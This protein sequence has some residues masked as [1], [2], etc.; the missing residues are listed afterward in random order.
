MLEFV[1]IFYFPPF[2]CISPISDFVVIPSD[3]EQ[4]HWQRSGTVPET[5]P[6]R[7]HPVQNSET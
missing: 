6:I 7:R 5:S 2:F 3:T 4:K 1:F